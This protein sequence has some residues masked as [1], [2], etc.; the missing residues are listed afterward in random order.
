NAFIYRTEAGITGGAPTS[1][2][3]QD[4]FNNRWTPTHPSNTYAGLKSTTS[5]FVSSYYVADASFVRFKNLSLGYTFDSPMLR[6]INVNHLRINF[7]V[8]NLHLWT[9]YSGLDPDVS[10]ATPLMRGYDRLSYP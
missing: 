9:D 6:R 5:S 4:Y 7:T 3:T 8:D 10:S 1:N 2:I